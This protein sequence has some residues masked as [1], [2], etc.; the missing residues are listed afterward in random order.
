MNVWHCLLH[1]DLFDIYCAMTHYT[2]KWSYFDSSRK[3]LIPQNFFNFQGCWNWMVFK[4]PSNWSHSVVMVRLQ[5]LVWWQPH[6]FF[7]LLFF[8][9]FFIFHPGQNFPVTTGDVSLEVKWVNYNKKGGIPQ[10]RQ[11][12]H[13]A[14][15]MKQRN[16]GEFHYL[17]S[18]VSLITDLNNMHI[19]TIRLFANVNQCNFRKVSWESEPV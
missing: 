19:N 6:I 4:A 3:D 18:F 15:E 7:P 17:T 11:F 13:F 10:S 2:C 14:A 12:S 16:P 1:T 5:K 9:S 8:F